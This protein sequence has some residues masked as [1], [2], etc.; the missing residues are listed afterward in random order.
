MIVSS[1]AAGF[2]ERSRPSIVLLS[3]F[4]PEF[5][6]FGLA[7]NGTDRLFGLRIA[8]VIDTYDLSG[9]LLDSLAKGLSGM[10]LGLAYTGSSF[11]VADVTSD[12]IPEFDLAG[13]LL[14]SFGS[15]ATFTEGLDYPEGV[16]I[17]GVPEPASLAMLLLGL[18]MLSAACRKQS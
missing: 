14:N 16:Q 12:R 15:P 18:G 2:P 8:G 5:N 3:S 11:Y 6:L 17:P 10:T 9:T 1:L 13:N 7:S 4:S